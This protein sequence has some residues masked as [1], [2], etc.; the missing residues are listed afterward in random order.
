MGSASQKIPTTGVILTTDRGLA[1]T[2]FL[3]SIHFPAVYSIGDLIVRGGQGQG[4]LVVD[5]DL[6]VGGDFH[7]FGV[8]IVLGRFQT[9]GLGSQITGAVI[10]LNSDLEPQ[11]LSDNTRILYSSCAVAEALAGSGRGVLLRERSWLDMY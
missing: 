2:T 9:V 6:T 7:F 10:V 4:I 1:G 11:S 5:G 3:R 8:A